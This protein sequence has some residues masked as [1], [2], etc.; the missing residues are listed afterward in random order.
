MAPLNLTKRAGQNN[1][2]Y[3]NPSITRYS[4]GE[5]LSFFSSLWRGQVGIFLIQDDIFPPA[6]PP[7]TSLYKNGNRNKYKKYTIISMYKK[8]IDFPCQ[9]S[10]EFPLPCAFFISKLLRLRP[11]QGFQITIFTLYFYNTFKGI[12]T[13]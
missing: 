1:K 5:W 11:N 2:F 10:K 4:I 7:N 9:K 3:I 12:V 8:K 6:P 13:F